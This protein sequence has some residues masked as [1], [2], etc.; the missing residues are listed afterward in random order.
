MLGPFLESKTKDIYLPEEDPEYFDVFLHRLYR[1]ELLPK[2]LFT[3]SDSQLS[4]IVGLRYYYPMIDRFLLDRSFKIEAIN[5]FMRTEL[6]RGPRKLGIFVAH[7]IIA[8]IT[9]QDPLRQFVLDHVAFDCLLWDNGSERMDA[10][11]AELSIE[12]TRNFAKS[13]H[14]VA[15]KAAP[16]WSGN[17]WPREI[18]SIF[19]VIFCVEH[20]TEW[21]IANI[22]RYQTGYLK[23]PAE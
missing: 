19:C 2:M 15:T 13:I 10:F 23:K 18:K 21:N 12:D 3:S 4:W 5:S 22:E 17:A 1:N 14:Y 8:A 9:E 6:L 7:R 20:E 11:N 16:F